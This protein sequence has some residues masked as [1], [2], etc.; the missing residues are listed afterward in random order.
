[1]INLS[2]V[3]ASMVIKRESSSLNFKS[4]KSSNL[5]FR[6]LIQPSEDRTI[7]TGSLGAI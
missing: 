7:E 4:P 3:L 6:D 5:P 2:L 1:M